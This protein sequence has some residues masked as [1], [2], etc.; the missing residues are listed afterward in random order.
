MTAGVVTVTPDM[1]LLHAAKILSDHD[2]TGLPVVDANG[3]LAGILTEYDLIAKG[4]A[5]HLPTLQKLLQSVPVKSDGTQDGIAKIASLAVRDVMNPDP[6]FF[7]KTA[8]IDEVVTLFR[9]HHRVNPVPVVNGNKKVVGV[10]SRSDILRLFDKVPY[11]PPAEFVAEGALNLLKNDYLF[12][13]KIAEEKISETL[14]YSKTFED[15]VVSS[16]DAV[17]ITDAKADVLYV[18]P[19]WERLNGYSLAEARGK[20]PRILKSGKTPQEVYKKMWETLVAGKPFVTE[21]VVNKRKDGTEYR[22]EITISPVRRDGATALY[23]GV[24]RDITKRK[25][26]EQAKS[27]YISLTAHQLATP[28]T[29]IGWNA[30]SLLGE[31]PGKLNREQRAHVEQI[32]VAS[33]TIRELADTFL[34]AAKIEAGVFALIPEPV[35]LADLVDKVIDDYG[36]ASREKGVMVRKE[37]GAGITPVTADRRMLRIIA[38]NLVSNAIRYTDAGGAVTVRIVQSEQ[39]VRLEVC[40]T[41]IGIPK[42]EQD[43]VFSKLFRARN[44]LT[45]MPDGTGLG[46]Y[47]VKMAAE[48]LGATINFISEEGKGTAFT[49]MLPKA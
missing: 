41:G 49:V 4:S 15:A 24:I 13:S 9:N 44:A 29:L 42:D 40:D 22:E 23:V 18:N 37:Y 32:V 20:N 16:T 47:V 27:E 17:A 8:S 12:L 31:K 39:G 26:I 46:L 48:K 5:V 35:N 6:M 36:L 38:Q 28:L 33:H 19:A 1:P 43:R 21:D 30:D 2:F 7:E 45:R 14:Q 3:V 34:N 11:Q 10:V 25:Q